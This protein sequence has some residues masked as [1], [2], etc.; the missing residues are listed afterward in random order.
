MPQNEHVNDP[1]NDRERYVVGVN[2]DPF[3]LRTLRAVLH[4]LNTDSSGRLRVSS[5]ATVLS[6][7][8]VTTVTNVTNLGN[9]TVAGMTI[10][11]Y[12]QHISRCGC[13]RDNLV[14]S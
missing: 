3:T 9:T 7:G 2:D 8:T 14:V 6:S 13:F 12:Q 4:K 10:V 5:E 11:A 1:V